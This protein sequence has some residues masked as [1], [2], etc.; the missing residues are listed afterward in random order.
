MTSSASGAPRTARRRVTVRVVEGNAEAHDAEGALR[1]DPLA[2]LEVTCNNALWF[3]PPETLTPSVT[4][5]I[6][7]R[8]AR[9]T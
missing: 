4:I 9:P 5:F 3:N 1:G 2:D 7:L 6:R 8:R